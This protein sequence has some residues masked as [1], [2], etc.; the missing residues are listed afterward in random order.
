[1]S[2]ASEFPPDVH[3][4]ERARRR[5]GSAVVLPFPAA[6]DPIGNDRVDRP[7]IGDDGLGWATEPER[8][9]IRLTRRGRLATVVAISV[10]LTGGVW[11][12]HASAGPS[13]PPQPPPATVT[14]GVGDTLWSVAARI[15]PNRDPRAV[16]AELAQENRLVDPT[17]RV[18]QVLRTR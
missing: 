11:L 13:T 1:M 15:A 6:A 18:G 8:G 2:A 5:S 7:G 12:A 9:A 10:A 4:P 14:V 17:V 3:I 16:V